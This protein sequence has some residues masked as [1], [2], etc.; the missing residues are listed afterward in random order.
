MK[1]FMQILKELKIA[2]KGFY[3]YV[4]VFITF[5]ILA[6]M[7]FLVPEEISSKKEEYL[8]YNMK[9][10]IQKLIIDKSIE[11]GLMK[12]IKDK[13]FK[14][15]PDSINVYPDRNTVP[16]KFDGIVLALNQN[17]LKDEK[18]KDG[19]FT[20]NFTDEKEITGTA[21]AV[22]DKK[23]GRLNKKLYLFKNFEDVLRLSKANRNIGAVIYYDVNKIE[24]YE[25]FFP[26]TVSGKYKNLIYAMH[27][28]NL[29]EILEDSSKTKIKYLG[30]IDKLNNRQNFIPLIIIYMNALM[31]LFIV[32]AYILND[33]VE[34]VIKALR[35]SPLSLRSILL[36]KIISTLPV[37][38]ISSLIITIPIM[39]L[40]A[41]YLLLSIIILC[42]SFFASSIA[43][44]I[45]SI[46]DSIKSSFG[47]I[48]ILFIIFMLP[49]L[50]YHIPSF[51]PFWI[52]YIPTHY[53]LLSVKY[54]ISQ[55][56]NYIFTLLSSLILVI[57]SI[58]IIEISVYIFKR[59]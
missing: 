2:S 21:Y 5:L 51:S 32:S 16:N 11:K 59:K 6:I 38:L 23:G 1:I 12:K 14:L 57:L 8:F 29:Y 52:N 50:S 33:K 56:N 36:A 9:P 35:V 37:S 17:K 27:N 30:E 43:L 3:F 25:M 7:F 39:K 28:D 58:P 18:N 19:S 49:I 42:T 48:F 31:G 15:K 13:N 54:C 10:E 22:Y 20:F 46:F 40:Q 47:I 34:G 44:L 45:S 41:N 55:N 53:I 26:F 24:H 4:E